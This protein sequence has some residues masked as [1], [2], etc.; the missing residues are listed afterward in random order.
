MN[1]T[2][3]L[4][5]TSLT[6]VPRV[7]YNMRAPTAHQLRK[8]SS[9]TVRSLPATERTYHSIAK[10][11]WRLS[12]SRLSMMAF[13]IEAIVRTFSTLNSE[14][15][16]ASQDPT[17]TSTLCLLL[18]SAPPSLRMAKRIQ[19]RDRWTCFWKKRSTSTTCPQ[20]SEAG[21]K[22]AKFLF[23]VTAP[24]RQLP[25]RAGWRMALKRR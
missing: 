12:C 18:I 9:A 8:D 4:V 2:L 16:A 14:W 11:Q 3:P 7:S 5:S 1:F 10:P 24:S 25:E 20:I 17:R 13:P 22:T 23:R 21:S 15:W 19:S 6:S